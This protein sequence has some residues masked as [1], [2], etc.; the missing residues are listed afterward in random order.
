[1]RQPHVRPARDD[2]PV[3][4]RSRAMT[5]TTPKGFRA[6]ASPA[7]SRAAAARRR[8]GRQR[9]PDCTAAGVFTGNRVKAAPC[10]GASR[11]SRAASCAPSCSTRAGPTLHRLAGLPRHARDRRAHRDRAARR[12]ETA[13]DRPGDVAVCSTGLIGELLPMAKLL[14]GRRR[15]GRRRSRRTAG[16]RPPRRS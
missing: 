10:S 1:V 12:L 8:A 7:G 6:A 15:G 4:V 16:L 11:F 5:V 9:R 14:P 3:R 13:A 2:G